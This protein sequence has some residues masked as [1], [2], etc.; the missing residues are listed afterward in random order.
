MTDTPRFKP[1]SG[2]SARK[3]RTYY[4]K[5]IQKILHEERK[6]LTAGDIKRLLIAKANNGVLIQKHAIPSS[7]TIAASAIRSPT[8]DHRLMSLKERP[9]FSGSH[10]LYSCAC[11]ECKDN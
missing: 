8:I 2:N 6:P 5:L 4:A 7:G 10:N 9:A 3:S 1:L 11:E